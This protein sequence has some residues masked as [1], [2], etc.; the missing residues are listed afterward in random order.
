MDMVEKEWLLTFVNVYL[1]LNIQMV[2]TEYKRKIY[3]ERY[4]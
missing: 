4:L 1:S 2:H 3:T